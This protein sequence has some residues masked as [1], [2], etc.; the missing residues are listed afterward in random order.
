MAGKAKDE[1]HDGEHEIL[2]NQTI[3]K[4]TEDIAA[5]KFNTAISSLMILV[6]AL[7]NG[8]HC[9]KGTIAILLKLVAPFAPHVA[10]ELWAGMGNETSIHL[11]S[12]PSYDPSKLEDDVANIAIQINGKT[13]EVL[14]TVKDLTEE[15]VLKAA[16]AL[17]GV[18]KWTKELP[19]KRVIWVKNRILNLIIDL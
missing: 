17:P 10:E 8:E 4:V 7:D 16:L 18:I 9:A 1:H 19:I 14:V 5:M 2:L 6:N 13:R 12:W 11:E 15:A 3:K